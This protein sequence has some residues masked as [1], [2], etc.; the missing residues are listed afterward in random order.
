MTY[1]EFKA[2]V[3]EY[4]ELVDKGLKKQ[5][6]KTLFELADRFKAEVSEDEADGILHLFCR[7]IL[8][9]NGYPKFREFGFRGTTQLPFQLSGLVFDYLIRECEKNKM[10]QMRWEYQL[11]GKYYNPHDPKCEHS[12]YEILERA[13][14]H[15][16]CDRLTVDLYFDAQLNEL[17]F[18]AH[19]FPEGCCISR[20]YYEECVSVCEKILSEKTI[21]PEMEREYREY[22]TLYELFYNW[23]DNGRVGR[24]DEICRDA[25]LDFAPV[26]AYY[27]TK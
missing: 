12:P 27:Y 13:Y 16:E 5:A 24:F 9:D 1:G 23:I 26:P 8:E 2:G 4:I 6:N 18:G 15:P 10:P 20:E 3:D 25:G 21:S 19:H 22:K 7:D 11:F 14:N 17:G